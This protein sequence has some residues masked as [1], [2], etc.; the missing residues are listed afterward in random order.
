[1]PKKARVF[2]EKMIFAFTSIRRRIVG[3]T[4]FAKHFKKLLINSVEIID[5]TANSVIMKK[6]SPIG[7]NS[8]DSFYTVL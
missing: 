2:F 3:I 6:E 1:M 8:D 4:V 7:P 5:N